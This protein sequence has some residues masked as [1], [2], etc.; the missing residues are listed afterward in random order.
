MAGTPIA[1]RLA[2]RLER[3]GG[4]ETLCDR[5]SGAETLTE[6][7]VEYGIHRATLM[8][9]INKVEERRLAYDRAKAESADTLVEEAGKILDDAPTETGP[10]IQKAKS[11]AEHRRWLAGK[12][13]REQYGED[14]KL[15]VGVHLDLGDLHL[16]ALRAEGHMDKRIPVVDAEVLCEG[17]DEG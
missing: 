9:W 2:K 16:S 8:R 11:R 12:R 13:D 1:N 14:A 3:D 7:A 5:V 4:I 6:I 10:E 17:D 15:A